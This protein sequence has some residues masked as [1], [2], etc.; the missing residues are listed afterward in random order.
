[1][2]CTIESPRPGAAGRFG[3]GGV[4]AEEAVENARQGFGRDADASVGDFDRDVVALGAGGDGDAT[5]GGRVDDGV[6]DEVADGALHEGA[7]EGGEDRGADDIAGEDDACFSGGRVV[8]VAHAV[9]QAGDVDAVELEVG[10][11]ALGAGEK[12]QVADEVGEV[13]G[14]FEGG[15]EGLAI[16]VDGAAACEGDLGLAANVIDR[17]AEVVGDIGGEAGDTLEGV[18]KAVEHAIEGV[19]EGGQLVGVACGG[20][21]FGEVG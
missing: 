5:A 12:E 7:I 2:P 11:G 8:I 14:F 3:A 6:G 13:D 9:E 19:G 1:M 15:L 16:F 21:A 18:F 20:D 4:D 17:R 10:E